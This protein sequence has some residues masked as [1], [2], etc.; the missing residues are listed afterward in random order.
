MNTKLT[1]EEKLPD[2]EQVL[3]TWTINPD[4]RTGINAVGIA[5]DSHG[6]CHQFTAQIGIGKARYFGA[7]TL[8]EKTGLRVQGEEQWQHLAAP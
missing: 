7:L 2:G 5:C 6:T 8:P 1:T 4:V 3:V